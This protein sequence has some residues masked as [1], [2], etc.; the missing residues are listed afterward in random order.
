MSVWLSK[1]EGQRRFNDKL[2]TYAD[3]MVSLEQ[4]GQASAHMLSSQEASES[5]PVA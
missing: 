5:A 1:L 3:R 2:N 4:H